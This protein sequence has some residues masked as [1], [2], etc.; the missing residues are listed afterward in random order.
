VAHST[1]LLED[2]KALVQRLE[3]SGCL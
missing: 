3:E 1:G 2:A